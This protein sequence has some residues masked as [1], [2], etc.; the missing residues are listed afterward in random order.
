M[1]S[2]S[3]SCIDRLQKL[4][5]LFNRPGKKFGLRCFEGFTGFMEEERGWH[6]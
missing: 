5:L 2:V 6:C 4:R 3:S 1:N